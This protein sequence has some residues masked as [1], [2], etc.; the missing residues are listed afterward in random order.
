RGV[1]REGLATPPNALDG[2]ACGGIGIRGGDRLDADG[3]VSR[4]DAAMDDAPRPDEPDSEV[5]RHRLEE[6]G[7][8]QLESD[9]VL[10]SH[11]TPPMAPLTGVARE[12]RLPRVLRPRRSAPDPRFRSPQRRGT[13]APKALRGSA[14][15]SLPRAHPPS[16]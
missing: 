3:P 15:T 1:T 9:Q 4:H 16:P 14:A 6:A 5:V 7:G 13:P 8:A 11:W 10:A 12:T 2:V